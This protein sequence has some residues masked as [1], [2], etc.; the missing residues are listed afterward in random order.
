MLAAATTVVGCDRP[1][2]IEPTS[3][4]RESYQDQIDVDALPPKTRQLYDLLLDGKLTGA[5]STEYIHL[6]HAAQKIT[7]RPEVSIYEFQLCG[8]PQSYQEVTEEG[9]P[10][11]FVKVQ[12][13][14]NL[15]FRADIGAPEF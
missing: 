14:F 12:K 2:A 4:T 15:I 5:N 10:F 1:Y 6:L 3:A 8:F 13:S 7:H 9:V 11:L